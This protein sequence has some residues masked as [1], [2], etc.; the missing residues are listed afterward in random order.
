MSLN[1]KTSI[2]CLTLELLNQVKMLALGL[3]KLGDRLPLFVQQLLNFNKL[4][5]L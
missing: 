1:T 4:L 3:A 5:L 2:F